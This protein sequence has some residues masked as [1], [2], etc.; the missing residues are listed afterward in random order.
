MYCLFV[1]LQKSFKVTKTL[2]YQVK[3][4]VA[5]FIMKNKIEHF[6]FTLRMKSIGALELLLCYSST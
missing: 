2:L 5:S 4:P 6:F 3:F 1:R